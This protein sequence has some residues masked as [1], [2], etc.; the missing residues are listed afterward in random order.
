MKTKR[1]RL[2]LLAAIAAVVLITA[3]AAWYFGSFATVNSVR[4]RKDA[5]AL[6]LSGAPIGQV[7]ALARFHNLKTL[8]LRGTGLTVA[9]YEKV[10]AMHPDC[11]IHWDIPFQGGYLEEGLETIAVTALT[12]ADVA[13]LGYAKT[14]K[15]VESA[16]CKDYVQLAQLQK[17]LPE[18]VFT[19]EISL[20]GETWKNDADQLVLED[21]DSNALMEALSW[22]PKLEKVRLLGKLPAPEQMDA[23]LAAYPGLD[24]SWQLD[25]KG[26]KLEKESEELELSGKQMTVTDLE[27]FLYYG[28][29]LQKLIVLDCGLSSEDLQD[30]QEKHTDVQVV[31][32]IDVEGRKFRT[33]ITEMDLSGISFADVEQV[34]TYISCFPNLTRVVLKDSGLSYEELD[35]LNKKYE[36]IRIVW[37]LQMTEKGSGIWTD[38]TYFM[39]YKLGAI[40]TDAE[41]EL[42]KYCPD[43]ICVDVGHMS[44]TKCD[45]VKH[46]PKLQYLIMADTRLEDIEPLRGHE[47]LIFLEIFLTKVTDYTPLLDCPNLLDLNVTNNFGDLTPLTKMTWLERLWVAPLGTNSYKTMP[48]V[49]MLQEAL[50]NTQVVYSDNSTGAGWREHPRYFEMRD[51]LEMF[52]LK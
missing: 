40:V 36:D 49:L 18:A 15:T 31:R 45:F 24:I 39:P 3:A 19:H 37:F 8:D 28:P 43:L 23:L 47:N 12:D 13:A 35:A 27:T 1:S 46:L 2:V 33:D 41:M 5:E 17:L 10:Q 26:V 50:P 7:E 52:Y 44:I 38:A 21:M 51:I 34:E 29:S 16:G 9:D 30:F 32:E 42:L 48:E 22:F 14:L 20:G 4:Y 6:D 25:V 11:Q